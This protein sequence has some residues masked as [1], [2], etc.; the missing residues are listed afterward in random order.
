MTETIIQIDCQHLQ[1]WGTKFM[2]SKN[3]NLN[4]DIKYIFLN[5]SDM[6]SLTSIIIKWLKEKDIINTNI[7]MWIAKRHIWKETEKCKKRIN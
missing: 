2:L 1:K 3:E 6:C 7:K 5:S 4:Y